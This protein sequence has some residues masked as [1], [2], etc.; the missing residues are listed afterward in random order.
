MTVVL[1]KGAGGWLIH[2]WTWTGPN[3]KP[4]AAPAAKP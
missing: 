2:G 4:V 3:P 1:A